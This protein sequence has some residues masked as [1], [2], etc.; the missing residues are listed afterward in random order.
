MQPSRNVSSSQWR[1]GFSWSGG[2]T[3]SLAIFSDTTRGMQ[4]HQPTNV[5][6]HEEGY[7]E[8]RTFFHIYFSMFWQAWAQSYRNLA[9]R[10]T[11]EG[12]SNSS[13][14]KWKF[15]VAVS[16]LEA[17]VT[18]YNTICCLQELFWKK[19]NHK[20]YPKAALQ[21]VERKK[22]SVYQDNKFTF[23]IM[24]SISLFTY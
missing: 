16:T 14:V 23:S 21:K 11:F 12:K 1:D 10:V 5:C 7:W 17:F 24:D 13:S 20:F 9:E 3:M 15:D 22:P 8:H 6:V 4:W 2:Q 19:K 18:K